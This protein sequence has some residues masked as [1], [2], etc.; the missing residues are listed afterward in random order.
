MAARPNVV[1][2]LRRAD[3]VQGTDTPV[4][5]VP[6]GRSPAKCGSCKGRELGNTQSVKNKTRPSFLMAAKINIPSADYD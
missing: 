2:T 5:S 1:K 3:T 4:G 6:S